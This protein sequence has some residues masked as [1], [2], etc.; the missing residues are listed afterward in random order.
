MMELP[1]QVHTALTRLEEAGFQAY[2]VGG[3]VRDYV[4]SGAPAKD[5]DITTNALPQEVERVFAAF[6]II[7]TGLR[8]GTVTVILDDLPLEITTYRIDGGYTDGRHP[9]AV[10]FTGEL[11]QDLAR[12]DFTMNALA[13]HPVRGVVD[14]FGGIAD[15][16][17]G[18]IRCVGEPMKRFQEDGLRILR[19]LRFASVY[20]M[21]LEENTAQALH[22]CKDLLT[23]VAA[24][25]I[26]VELTG[27]LCGPGAQRVLRDFSDVLAVVL[28]EVVP[29]FGF[30]QHNPHHDKDVWEHTLAVVSTAPPTAVLR[31]AALLHDIGKP[32]CFSIHEDGVGH[33]YGHAEKSTCLAE[34]ILERLHFDTARKTA[35]LQLVRYHDLPIPPERKPVLRLLRKLGEERLRQLIALHIAD[36]TGQAECCQSRVPLY[37]QVEEVLDELLR[38]SACFSLQELAVNG[39]DMLALGL[40]GRAV[41]NALERCLNAVMDGAVQNERGALLDFLQTEWENSGASSNTGGLDG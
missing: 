39:R 18:L 38:E 30:A 29:M 32:A 22:A 37:R 12:R 10:M 28:P 24:E 19:G 8:H 7:E 31:W 25:R 2:L 33:F 17:A 34:E 41:G 40:E 6:R 14:P 20:E 15:I 16:R 3:A 27:L 9:D 5:W 35:I 36:T 4:R 11:E 23:G 26:L 13:Y 21:E 1:Q